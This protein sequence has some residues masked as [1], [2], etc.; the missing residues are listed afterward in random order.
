[1]DDETPVRS[2]YKFSIQVAPNETKVIRG[3]VKNTKGIETA[4]IEQTNTT[5][6][7]SLV[8]CTRVV[9]LTKSK[10][11]VTVPVRVCNLSASTL[12]RFPG[13]WR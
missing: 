3:V 5:L 10:H 2:S 9:P 6:S 8:V 11:T 7:G 12:V 13:P 4:L 1:M